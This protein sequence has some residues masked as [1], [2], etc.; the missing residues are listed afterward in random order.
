VLR[1]HEVVAQDM[2]KAATAFLDSLSTEQRAKAVFALNDAERENWFFVPLARQGLPFKE[3]STTQQA[4]ALAFLRTGLSH[5]GFRRAQ[6]IIAL[7]LVLK[8]LEGGAARRDPTLYY[9]TIFGGP[10][11]SKSWGWRFE[12]H[13]LSF[14]F[15]VVD[16]H[17]V[18]F[19]PSFIGSN[20]A[21]VPIGPR[22]GERVLAE[23]DD[24]GRD[25]MKSLSPAQ[26]RVAR[27]S[28]KAP[29]DILTSNKK[30]VDPL[31]PEGIAF[32][33]L[34][35]PQRDALVALVKLYVGRWRPE[36]A[37]ETFAKISAVGLDK[38]IFAW[39]GG[40]ERGDGNYY[41]IQGPTFLIEFDNVQNRA[42]H[43]HTV[44]REFEGDF[45]RDLLQEHYQQHKH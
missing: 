19:A 11:E 36:L 22:K 5:S 2:F 27:F 44:F 29:A 40:L 8:E 7:E 39:A 37:G 38:L 9:V 21:E 1:A 45:G 12:G 16:G 4:L 42:N 20:P 13:H 28:D 14:N 31:S 30:R 26:Q 6:E 15:T 10:S 18:A 32:T 41:R 33:A 34:T 25:F 3:M 17:H 35:P 24:L 23:E 43:I